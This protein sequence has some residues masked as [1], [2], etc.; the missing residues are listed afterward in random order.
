MKHAINGMPLLCLL[1]VV[2]SNNEGAHAFQLPSRTATGA[3]TY[4][5]FT[6]QTSM[7]SLQPYTTY[8]N[9]VTARYALP[10]TMQHIFDHFH[11]FRTSTSSFLSSTNMLGLPTTIDLP[12]QQHGQTLFEMLDVGGALRS[13]VAR[14][15]EAATSMVLESVGRDLLVFLMASVVVTPLATYLKVTPILGYL[16]AGALLG[17]HAMD[18]FSN[19][20]ADVELG[21]F[22]IL[23]LLFSEG[24]EVSTARLQK[25][26]NYLPLGLAQLS[27]TAGVLTTAILA[28]AP[29]FL[30]RFIDLD[31]G[32]INIQNPSE[33]LV[34]ALAG[35]LSTS[36]F[37]FPV[38]KDLEWEE[39]ESGQ[40]ATSILLL[41]DLA[42]APLLVLMPFVIGQGETDYAAIGFLT[43]KATLGFGSVILIGS[44]V[45]RRLF[46]LVARARSTET[47]VA[48]CLLVSVGIG[49]LAKML[50]LTDTAGAFAAGVLLANTNYR[51][52]IQADILPFKG[53]LLGIF[54]MD[55]GSSFD[56]ELVM[57]ELPTV[58]TGAVALL[59]L[60]AI[61]LFAATRVPRWMEPNRLPT[62]D[63][64]RLALLLSG[65]GEFAFVVLALAE[66]L[67]VLPR[68]LGGLLT[69]IVLITMSATP[70]LG[71]LAKALTENM[72]ESSERSSEMSKANEEASVVASNAV[73]V[74]GYGEIGQ[75]LLRALAI[76]HQ[77]EDIQPSLPGV[78]AFDTDSSLS[79]IV[80]MPQEGT[81]V[82]FGDAAN[83]QVL[84]SS[85]ITD[86]AAIYVTYEDHYRV[87][88]AT[89]R[90]RAGFDH[91]PI[92]ARAQTRA[93]AH[94]LK[95]AGAT[96]VVVESDELPRSAVTLLRMSQSMALTSPSMTQEQLRLAMAAAARITPE[97][98]DHLLDLFKCMDETESGFISASKILNV[99]RTSNSG[100]VSDDEMA[101]METWVSS[102]VKSPI[103]P[104]E[105][106]R[107]YLQAP[108]II[109]RSL[110]DACMI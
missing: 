97:E 99:L 49:E 3:A 106:C 59:I 2:I 41:Q 91:T 109:R 47:F 51:A 12:F 9:R 86:P 36:A 23:F 74:C 63:G 37:I 85:G 14:V 50:G 79:D 43:A 61:T 21:D 60:K 28:G 24:L 104:I 29:A 32:V 30:D 46:A 102:I 67:E 20:K 75:S 65:G 5:Y 4:R 93:E 26:A 11:L 94:S 69:A 105:F 40:A 25:L 31:D 64:V 81:I 107:L 68:E 18:V 87:L 45:L 34:L 89:S 13:N 66:R 22:G 88:S 98:V 6:P 84:R 44:F 48:L 82:L 33:A 56:V 15:P 70:I 16:L 78:V 10:Q 38:L 17:P 7:P 108:E 57:K 95:A 77:G 72:T 39:D 92:F 52:Q 35:A 54:F 100:I 96:E 110:S 90:L 83:P 8:H 42:V 62:V 101:R 53:I 80:L 76:E 58:L 55:A 1:A 27:L 73:I 103:P 19:S 71:D